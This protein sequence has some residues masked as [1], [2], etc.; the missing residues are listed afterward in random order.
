MMNVSKIKRFL[1]KNKYERKLSFV[2]NM[3]SLINKRKFAHIGAKSFFWDPIFLSGTKY[4]HMGK[5]VGI[6]HH[7]RVE[8]ID[9]WEGQR[10]MPSLRIG[11]HVNIGQ[12]CHITLAE[13][14][15][16]E[17][18]VV[19]S[20]RVTIT[21]ISHVT[22]D[23]EKAV[24]NQGVITSPVKIKRG[25]FVG[26]NAIILPGVTIGKHAIVGAGAV[27]TKDVPDYTTVVGCPAQ[28]LVKR[29]KA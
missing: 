5:E 14:I 18:D 11:D 2:R 19:C 7:A 29:E 26:I 22:D 21:D 3:Y 1:K 12:D 6:W 27:V 20:A 4:I 13:N 8:V 16:I 17:D 28:S 9:E 10:F 23:P 15:D 24:L 25:A